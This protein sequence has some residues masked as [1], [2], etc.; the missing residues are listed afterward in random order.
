MTIL[1]STSTLPDPFG[2]SVIVPFTP[3]AIVIDPELVPTLVFNTKL[4][5]PLDDIVAVAP[6]S[7]TT[8]VSADNTTF[9]VPFGVKVM[10][11][12]DPST[13]VITQVLEL[14]V[15]KTRS[16]FPFDWMT[17]LVSVFPIVNPPKRAFP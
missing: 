11:P 14:T 5:A 15:C 13:I 12:F 17:P 4:P 1:E 8:T 9:P 3:F 6:E 7:P 10:F 2:S 16:L